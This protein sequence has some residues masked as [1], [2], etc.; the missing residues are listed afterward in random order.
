[1]KGRMSID[2]KQWAIAIDNWQLTMGAGA[3]DACA[4]APVPAHGQA[5]N[6]PALTKIICFGNA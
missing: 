6:T 5:G 2:N 4:S 1:M 3:S